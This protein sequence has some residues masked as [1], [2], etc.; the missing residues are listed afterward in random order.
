MFSDR[1]QRI[2]EKAQSSQVLRCHFRWKYRVAMVFTLIHLRKQCAFPVG[3]TLHGITSLVENGVG[4]LLGNLDKLIQSQSV[5]Y[6]T[7][8]LFLFREI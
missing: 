1:G 4:N 8:T 7:I 5:P 2:L 3:K 6:G